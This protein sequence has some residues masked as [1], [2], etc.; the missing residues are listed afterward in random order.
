MSHTRATTY[1]HGASIHIVDG[2]IKGGGEV[3]VDIW[4]EGHWM[5]PP[6]INICTSV[7]GG[8]DIVCVVI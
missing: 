8:L 7:S 4:R 2:W 1:L 5:T 3:Q 6:G